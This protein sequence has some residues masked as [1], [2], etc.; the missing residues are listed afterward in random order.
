MYGG[1]CDAAMI[2]K[3]D[4]ADVTHLQSQSQE[5]ASGDERLGCLVL[6]CHLSRN[7][8]L[9]A[10][11]RA[12]ETS[13]LIFVFRVTSYVHHEGGRARVFSMYLR[14][15]L[16]LSSR[17]KI[18]TLQAR[19]RRFVGDS[20]FHTSSRGAPFLSFLATQQRWYHHLQHVRTEFD[21]T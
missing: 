17:G 2:A 16:S 10:G 11:G 3:I 14:R 18:F 12:V 20:G 4:A 19:H 7:G 6:I 21:A 15:W 8:L 1:D 5:V 13:S 9:L